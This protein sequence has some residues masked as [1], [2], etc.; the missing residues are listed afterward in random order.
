MESKDIRPYLC[1]RCFGIAAP[2]MSAESC[3]AL[4]IHGHEEQGPQIMLEPQPIREEVVLSHSVP[5]C[6][7]DHHAGPKEGPKAN[8]LRPP[9]R[10]DAQPLSGAPHQLLPFPVGLLDPGVRVL[11]HQDESVEKEVFFSAI[12]LVL[13]RSFWWMECATDPEKQN[14]W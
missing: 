8:V 5:G 14:L 12:S 4:R 13:S 10:Q 2:E 7:H 3:L 9:G 6:Q 11:R 1:S